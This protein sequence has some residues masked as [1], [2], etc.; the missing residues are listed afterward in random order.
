MHQVF[1][2]MSSVPPPLKLWFKKVRLSLS[3]KKYEQSCQTKFKLIQAINIHN[4]VNTQKNHF[5]SRGMETTA[6]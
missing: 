1:F 2:I 5:Y 3:N 4:D 6:H